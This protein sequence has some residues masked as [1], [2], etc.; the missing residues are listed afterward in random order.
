MKSW[1]TGKNNLNCDCKD[2]HL[3]EEQQ[4]SKVNYDVSHSRAHNTI[5]NI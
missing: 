2:E 3:K 1:R 5:C 4:L